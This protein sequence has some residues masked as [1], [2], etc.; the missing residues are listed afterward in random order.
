MLFESTKKSL[1][2][3]FNYMIIKHRIFAAVLKSKYVRN[4]SVL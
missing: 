1:K 3:Q 2:L 4:L